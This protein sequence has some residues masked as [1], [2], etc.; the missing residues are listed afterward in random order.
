[1]LPGGSLCSRGYV[2][3]RNRQYASAPLSVA[4]LEALGERHLALVVLHQ[5]KKPSSV[6]RTDLH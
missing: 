1:M 3:T 4:D 6:D 5:P 2:N